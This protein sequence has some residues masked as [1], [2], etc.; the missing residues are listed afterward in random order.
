MSFVKVA[1]RRWLHHSMFPGQPSSGRLEPYRGG[2]CSGVR[3]NCEE[4]LVNQN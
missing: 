4:L 1:R 3:A 2:A